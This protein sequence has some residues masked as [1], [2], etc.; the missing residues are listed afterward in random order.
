M[1][2]KSSIIKQE[3]NISFKSKKCRCIT[4][5][6]NFNSSV[7]DHLNTS[8]SDNVIGYSNPP[9]INVHTKST[10]K[11]L[12]NLQKE[13]NTESINSINDEIMDNNNTSE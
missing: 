12:I 3:S 8:N 13:T 11:N 7:T 1:V 6:S 9:S 10:F 5:D 2:F 4:V